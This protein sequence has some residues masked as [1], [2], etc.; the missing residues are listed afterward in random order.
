VELWDRLKQLFNRG[1][2]RDP[3]LS[4][5]TAEQHFAEEPASE[6]GREL[7]DSLLRPPAGDR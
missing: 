4:D 1:R 6:Q 2:D 7:D 5:E 3:L